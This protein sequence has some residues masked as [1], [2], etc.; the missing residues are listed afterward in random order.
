MLKTKSHI[1]QQFLELNQSYNY[2]HT[3]MHYKYN[4]PIDA[5]N[6]NVNL[7]N[8]KRNDIFYSLDQLN[9]N[10]LREQYEYYSSISA[11]K[12]RKNENENDIVDLNQIS[13][14]ENLANQNEQLYYESINSSANSIEHQG[15]IKSLKDFSPMSYLNEN[16]QDTIINQ[17]ELNMNSKRNN[18]K[19]NCFLFSCLKQ[20]E[21]RFLYVL[22]IVLLFTILIGCIII[23]CLYAFGNLI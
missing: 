13:L 4:D 19:I 12:S 6:N 5:F 1:N 8:N 20:K 3:N 21:K 15:G 10:D 17:N 22:A 23:I 9:E 11:Q 7:N 2:D 14:I 18:Q 16:M